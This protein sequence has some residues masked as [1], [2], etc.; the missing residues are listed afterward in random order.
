MASLRRV[1]TRGRNGWQ[2]RFSLNKLRKVIWLPAIDEAAAVTWRQHVEHLVTTHGNSLPARTT[3]LWIASLSRGDQQK[4]AGVGLIEAISAPESSNPTAPASLKS[5][6]NWYISRRNAKP[7]TVAKWNQARDSLVKHFGDNRRVDSITIA[8][9][10]AWREWLSK[11]GNNREGKRDAEDRRTDLGDN[12][13]RRRTGIARQFFSYAIKAKLITENPFDGLPASVHG[14]QS[15]QFFVSMTLFKKV[16][17]HCP[18]LEWEAVIALSRIGGVRCPSETLRLRWE[19]IDFANGRMRIYASKTE[20]HKDGGI[21]DCPLFTDLRPYL[22]QLAELAKCRGAKPTD[23][24][25]AN[26]RGSESFLRAGMLR[27]LK[28]AGVAPWPKIFHN[29]RASRETELLDDFP[30]KDV[31]SWIGNSQ[32]VAMKHYAMR[33]EDSFARANGTLEM[34]GHNGSHKE[35]Q[36]Q[37]TPGNK[38]EA[39]TA[40]EEAKTQ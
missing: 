16:I 39:E 37:A 36:S 13:V 12:T 4:L 40:R 28:K 24:V 35:W 14:N 29:L 32:A 7:A 23:P 30:I 3:S 5:F 17:A 31:C 2:L 18:S 34:R 38:T 26:L 11:S 10:E 25:I 20:H 22:E 9:A 8:D 6:L 33:R 21:R 27:I 19:D 15:R 1:S